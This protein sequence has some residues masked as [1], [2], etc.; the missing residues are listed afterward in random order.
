[1]KTADHRLPRKLRREQAVAGRPAHRRPH[2]DPVE[3]VD[4]VVVGRRG[5][6]NRLGQQVPPKHQVRIV[7]RRLVANLSLLELG[8][9]GTGGGAISEATAAARARSVSVTRPL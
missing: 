6:E 3:P 9:A 1:M 7:G 4:L 8:H 5:D 2:G